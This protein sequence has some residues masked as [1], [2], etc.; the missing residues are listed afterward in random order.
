MVTTSH[1][2]L[3]VIIYMFI[4]CGSKRHVESLRCCQ[5]CSDEFDHRVQESQNNHHLFIGPPC[6]ILP[7]ISFTIDSYWVGQAKTIEEK[8]V[9][10]IETGPNDLILCYLHLSKHLVFVPQLFGTFLFSLSWKRKRWQRPRT[11]EFSVFF[12]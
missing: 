1:A 10:Y 8:N 3:S 12:L 7:Y 9:E 6:P 2:S 11:S 5:H 4:P